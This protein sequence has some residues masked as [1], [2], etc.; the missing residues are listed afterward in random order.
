MAGTIYFYLF[1]FIENMFLCILDI[2]ISAYLR[3]YI[4]KILGTIKSVITT[5]LLFIIERL[6]N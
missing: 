2:V 1:F 6:Q 4:Y 3:L 5:I